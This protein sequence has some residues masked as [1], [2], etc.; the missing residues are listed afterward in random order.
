MFRG[1]VGGGGLDI[2]SLSRGSAK[3]EVVYTSRSQHSSKTRY[4]ESPDLTRIKNGLM[5]SHDFG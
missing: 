4:L 1:S 2:T 3:A 5:T